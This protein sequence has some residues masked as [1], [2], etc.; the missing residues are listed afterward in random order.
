MMRPVSKILSAGVARSAPWLVI[1]A[2]LLLVLAAPVQAARRPA[3]ALFTI[4]YPGKTW[5]LV[6]DLRSFDLQRPVK[7][8]DGTAVSVRG[9]GRDEGLSIAVFVEKAAKEGDAE[10]C[11]KHYLKLAKHSP[12]YA[13]GDVILS[14]RDGMALAEYTVPE[15]QGVAINQKRLGAYMVREDVWITVQVSKREFKDEDQETLDKVLQSVRFKEFTPRRHGRQ[16]PAEPA[17]TN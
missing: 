10:V 15:Y 5:S 12:L 7:K 8:P 14:E 17:V 6:V 13:G 2:G 4:K 1:G 9:K 3:P 16:A 11:R